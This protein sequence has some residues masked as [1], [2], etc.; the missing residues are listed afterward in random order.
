MKEEFFILFSINFLSALGYS[1]IAPLYPSLAKER[2][3]GE[4]ICGITISMYAI[5]SFIITPL[6]PFLILKYGRKRIF[7]IAIILEVKY[8][9]NNRLYV[10]F[11]MDFLIFFQSNSLLF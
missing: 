7:Y 9:F 8:E 11:S 1:L 6:Y 4:N 5:S 10:P 3:I 2:N